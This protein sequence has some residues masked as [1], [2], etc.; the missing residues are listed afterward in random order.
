M[1]AGSGRARS[2]AILSAAFAPSQGGIERV[3]EIVARGLR[4]RGWNVLVIT[5]TQGG[6][7]DGVLRNPSPRQLV[8]ALRR[9]D[10]ILESHPSVRLSW[11]SILRLVGTRRVVVLHTVVGLPS[12]VLRLRD[13]V[14]RALLPRDN[15]YAV[16]DW[17]R[18]TQAPFAKVIANP[19]DAS[20][21]RRG[22]GL[23]RRGIIFLGRLV[24]AK[25]LDVLLTALSIGGL[26]ESL[27]VVGDGPERGKLQALAESLGVDA[28]FLGARHPDEV[29]D[30]L[31]SHHVL[32]VPSRSS[33]PEAFGL[34]AIEG[35]ASG[36]RVVVTDCGGLADTV[37]T[38]GAVARADDPGD[39]ADKLRSE[40]SLEQEP[41]SATL[42]SHYLDR[43]EAHSVLNDYEKILSDE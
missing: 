37:G 28:N 15:T 34:V 8:T 38:F 6:R 41:V 14:K 16:S 12:G 17:L 21:F 29:A 11:P 3:T 32:V 19:Y 26:N 18:R 4:E 20:L 35:L 30:L 9:A 10:V 33:P 23:E 13:R 40:L 25:G 22:P 27:T 39:L 7:I 36:C 1:N 31:R 43:F 24:S 2:V 5:S 42:L